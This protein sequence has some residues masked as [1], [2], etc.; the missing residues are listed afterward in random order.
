MYAKAVRLF[1]SDTVTINVFV[2]CTPQNSEKELQELALAE[3]RRVLSV[4]QVSGLTLHEGD[5]APA[6]AKNESEAV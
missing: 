6:G 2:Y 4:V 5:I 1:L 3:F